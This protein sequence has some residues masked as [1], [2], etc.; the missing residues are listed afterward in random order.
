MA[1]KKVCSSDNDR[2]M[3]LQRFSSLLAE[4]ETECFVWA[5]IPNSPPVAHPFN[6]AKTTC[7]TDKT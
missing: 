1:R 6:P 4:T 2:A 3:F 7:D 5:L